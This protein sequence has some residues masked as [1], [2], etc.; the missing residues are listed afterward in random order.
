MGRKKGKQS[1][2][3]ASKLKRSEFYAE[4][5]LHA[6]QHN[7][8]SRRSMPSNT[9]I[10]THDSSVPTLSRPRIEVNVNQLRGL[11]RE[12][13]LEDRQRDASFRRATRISSANMEQAYEAQSVKSEIET[14][15]IG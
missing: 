14:M 15:K 13:I 10:S 7:S 6:S 8:T 4:I 3:F 11:L 1:G 9:I 12:R 5:S 2:L